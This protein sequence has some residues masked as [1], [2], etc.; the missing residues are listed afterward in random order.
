MNK[1]KNTIHVIAKKYKNVK[2]IEL[3]P[4]KKLCNVKYDKLGLDFK[5]KDIPE[6][7]PLIVKEKEKELN[8]ELF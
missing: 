7:S 8:C 3:L 2:S 6:P 4:F 5:F 1:N